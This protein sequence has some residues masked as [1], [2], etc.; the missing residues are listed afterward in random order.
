M[1][2]QSLVDEVASEADAFLA[3]VDGRKDARDAISDYLY[4]TYPSLSRKEHTV[5]VNGVLEVLES[6]D[7]FGG[8]PAD[9]EWSDRDDIDDG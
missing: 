7:F 4:E 8:G 9:G 3:T 6:E 1:N 2:L 5:V